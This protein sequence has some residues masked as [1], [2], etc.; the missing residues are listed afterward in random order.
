M[1]IYK[2]EKLDQYSQL[3]AVQ[4]PVGYQK[5]EAKPLYFDEAALDAHL[6]SLSIDPARGLD[7]GE[8]RSYQS[9]LGTFTVTEIQ[10]QTVTQSASDVKAE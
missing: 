9:H 2:L 7:N 10:V 4:A 8:F 5:P 3:T 1:K 6:R